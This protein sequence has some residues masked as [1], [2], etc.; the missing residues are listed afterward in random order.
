MR[1]PA[2]WY[3]PSAR[4]APALLS[5]FGWIT[6]EATSRRLRRRGWRP[7]VPVI[8]CGNI[9]VGGAGKTTLA[10]DLLSRLRA[11]GIDA[12]ALTRGYG[13]AARGVLRVDPTRHDARLAGDEALLLAA[14]AV[15]WV[16]ADRVAAARDAVAAGAQCLVMDDGLQNPGLAQDCTLL[17]VDGAVGFGN[18]RLLPAGPLRESVASG[19]ARAHAAI[20]IGPDR[21]GALSRLP[22]S[23][24]VLRAS[25]ALDPGAGA[26]RGQ[27]LVA[28][29]GIGRP[30]KF[31]DSLVAAGLELA[32]RVG[33]ADHH[34]YRPAELRHLAARAARE[35]ARLVTTPKDAVR[36]PEPFRRQ[37]AV[38]GVGLLWEDAALVEALLDGVVAGHTGRAA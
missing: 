2:F 17:V 18:A 8:C 34:R 10:L 24:P 37:V 28:F 20:L 11:R 22:A 16:A 25:L 21:A 12:H 33:F 19:A 23:L 35:R 36:L 32:A 15:T 13:G 27:R 1:G 26:L 5:P 6:A 38:L 7:P 31:F 29:A 9:G 14:S 30:G 4:L 3:D